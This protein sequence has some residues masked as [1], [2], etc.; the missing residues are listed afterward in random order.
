MK[1]TGNFYCLDSLTYNIQS[2]VLAPLKKILTMYQI[3]NELLRSVKK[4]FEK[5]NNHFKIL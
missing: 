5:K 1:K 2:C 3:T 4:L